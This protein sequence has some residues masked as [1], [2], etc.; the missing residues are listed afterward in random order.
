MG[1]SNP[2]TFSRGKKKLVSQG[3]NVMKLQMQLEQQQLNTKESDQV[4]E[5]PKTNKDRTKI[6]FTTDSN[7]Q[8]RIKVP[9]E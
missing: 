1:Q 9:I 7:G 5:S 6:G 2:K 3:R 4:F 8:T